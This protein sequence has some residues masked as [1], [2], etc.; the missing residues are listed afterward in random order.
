MGMPWW[1]DASKSELINARRRVRW[2]YLTHYLL[3][4]RESRVGLK[5]EINLYTR[6]IKQ[7]SAGPRAL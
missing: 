1:T 5:S 6:L 3:M 4:G 2:A 7:H